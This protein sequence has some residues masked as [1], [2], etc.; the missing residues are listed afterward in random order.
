VPL[1]RSASKP[2]V[3]RS[4]VPQKKD[5]SQYREE[6]RHDFCY[7]CAYCTMAEAESLGFGFE[8]DHYLPWQKRLDLKH[9]YSNLEWS[10]QPCNRNKSDYMPGAPQSERGFFVLR[11]DEHDPRLHLQLRPDD[12]EQLIA[13]TNT[14]EFNIKL[15]NLNGAVLRR[16]RSI[17]LRHVQARDVV[18]EGYRA[19]LR[20]DETRIRKDEMEAVRQLR[21]AAKA[22][23]DELVR[24]IREQIR[25]VNRSSLRDAA[26]TEPPR[27]IRE[28]LAEVSS[29][30][31]VAPASLPR[32]GKP[33]MSTESRKRRKKKRKQSRESRRLNRPE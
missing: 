30:S 16:L 11:P 10:C 31:S 4:P 33:S 23:G 12:P 15:L 32:E 3:Q 26:A 2:I 22:R 5:Y 13:Q 28:F 7:A 1:E 6:L 18:A 27:R 21:N 24:S 20:L 19:L 9:T 14:G 29:L 8:I 17:R 25:Q